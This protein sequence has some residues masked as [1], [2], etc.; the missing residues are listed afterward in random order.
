MTEREQ[1]KV[2]KDVD[3]YMTLKIEMEEIRERIEDAVADVDVDD[4]KFILMG[5]VGILTKEYR[6][7][8]KVNTSRFIDALKGHPLLKTVNMTHKMLRA[9]GALMDMLGI[10][11]PQ[12]YAKLVLSP[13]AFESVLDSDVADEATVT[14]S[15]PRKKLALKPRRKK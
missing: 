12:K 3:K 11:I 1:R 2:I 13:Y 4:E 9:G 10:T 15:R 7:F 6:T 5:E 14:I 8:K